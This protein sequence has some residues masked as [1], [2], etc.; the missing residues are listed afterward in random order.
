[1]GKPI[2]NEV[3]LVTYV[4]CHVCF[5]IEKKNKVLVAKWDSIKKHACKRK[6]LD[7]KWF[8]DPKCGHAKNESTYAQLL[9]TIVLQQ[10]DIGQAM[11]DKRKLVQFA[12]IFNFL[13]KGKPMTDYEYLKPFFEFV[14]LRPIL[15]KHWT[16]GASWKM[17]EHTKNEVKKTTKIVIKIAK[18]VSLTCD[19]VTSMDNASWASVRGYILQDWCRIPLLN[20]KHVLFGSRANNLTLLIMNSL[21]TQ[22]GLQDE[23]LAS[24][25]VCFGANGV[26]TF[27]GIKSRITVQIQWEYVPFVTYIYCMAHQTNLVIQTLSHLPLASRIEAL[28]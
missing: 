26:N 25:L 8:M 3:G 23:N 13:N 18:F 12:F 19:E 10:L 28:L 2:F 16:Y 5:K 27:Q 22:G 11:E 21:M 1:M 17:V 9:G 15:K 4:T 14:K 7:G 6:A 20:V 24:K